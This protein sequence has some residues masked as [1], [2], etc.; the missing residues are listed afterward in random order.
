MIPHV[1]HQHHEFLP[2]GQVGVSCVLIR[3]GFPQ[4]PLKLFVTTVCVYW[5]LVT[6][7]LVY[8]RLHL[9]LCWNT[10]IYWEERDVDHQ[11]S[12]WGKWHTTL[13]QI[14]VVAGELIKVLPRQLRLPDQGLPVLLEY[15]HQ[16]QTQNM[17]LLFQFLVRNPPEKVFISLKC[18]III[19]TVFIHFY[20]NIRFYLF[21]EDLV[22]IT[23]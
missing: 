12:S 22:I 23:S 21:R 8:Q 7:Q 19:L 18:I 20:L 16:A 15:R 9:R 5:S 17:K 4:I 11:W 6:L 2:V 14:S 3:V 10:I 13:V 1:L